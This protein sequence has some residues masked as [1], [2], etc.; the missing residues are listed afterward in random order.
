MRPTFSGL[1]ELQRLSENYDLT[2]LPALGRNNQVRCVPTR[3]SR[4]SDAAARVIH[5]AQAN[6]IIFLTTLC[7]RVWCQV[8]LGEDRNAK[9]KGPKPVVLF[10]RAIAVD[11][12]MVGPGPPGS[13]V[14]GDELIESN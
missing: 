8:Y 3:S 4:P 9:G 1:L 7:T 11:N 5:H 10:T 14:G 6:Y 2:R 13:Q 12:A